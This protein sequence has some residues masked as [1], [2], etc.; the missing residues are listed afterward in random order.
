MSTFETAYSTLIECYD[1]IQEAVNSGRLPEF[2]ANMST[3][4]R[5][6]FRYMRAQLWCMIDAYDEVATLAVEYGVQI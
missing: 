5:V 3:E 4:E 6:S 1:S 2:L